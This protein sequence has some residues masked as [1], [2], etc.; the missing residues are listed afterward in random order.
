[1]VNGARQCGVNNTVIDMG[2]KVWPF[3]ILNVPKVK[4]KT[5]A[6]HEATH[7]SFC[8]FDTVCNV[9]SI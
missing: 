5:V 8:L 3:L 1:M 4:L 7:A 6:G 9:K 2:T